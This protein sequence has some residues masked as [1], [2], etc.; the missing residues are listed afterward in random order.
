MKVEKK[1]ILSRQK[2]TLF[3]YDILDKQLYLNYLQI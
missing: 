1:G 3:I 2:L